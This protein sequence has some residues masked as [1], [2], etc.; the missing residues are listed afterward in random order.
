MRLQLFL[1]IAADRF[2]EG[3]RFWSAVTGS[4]PSARRGEAGQF[5]TLLPPA[6]APWVKLQ[7]VEGASRCHID[8]EVPDR[9]AAVERSTTL[10]AIP[11]WTYDDVE[12]LRSPGGLLFCLASGTSDPGIVRDGEAT[13]DQVCVDIPSTRW[14]VDVDFWAD[15]TGRKPTASSREEFVALPRPG[16]P[17]LLLQ[18]LD[19]VDGPVGA[20]P[21]FACSDR[22]A[23]AATHLSLGAEIVSEHPWWTVLRAPTGHHYCLTDRDPGTG[24]P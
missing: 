13:L 9:K 21:D 20:H 17:R 4:T 12:V 23:S 11:A 15:L 8:L 1:D 10:G 19:S 6:G 2:E 5:L 3:V 22:P 18:R 16:H 14:S 7:A 24:D